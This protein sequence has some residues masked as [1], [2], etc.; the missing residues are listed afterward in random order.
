MF[1]Q[2]FLKNLVFIWP[3][4]QLWNLA[5]L[6]LLMAKFGFFTFWDMATLIEILLYSFS[7]I[8]ICLNFDFYKFEMLR[9]T[10][11]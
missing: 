11:S 4:F 6:K 10:S 8:Q 1:W 3:F 9:K 2:I 7:I 5:F